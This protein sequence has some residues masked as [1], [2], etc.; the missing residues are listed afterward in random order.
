MMRLRHGGKTLSRMEGR[1]YEL[2]LLLCLFPT[3]S[4]DA[5]QQ[6]SLLYIVYLLGY[7]YGKSRT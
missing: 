4:A 2:C 6:V 5:L 3:T 7:G 1:S